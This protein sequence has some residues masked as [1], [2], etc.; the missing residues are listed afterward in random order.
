M[1][2]NKKIDELAPVPSPINATVYVAKD[3]VD[4][5]ATAGGANGLATLDASG[6]LP[7]SQVTPPTWGTITGTISAQADLSAA[8]AGKANVTHTHLIAD[9]TGLQTSLDSKLNLSGGNLT[10]QL[11][12]FQG[13][14]TT[15]QTYRR[16]GWNNNILRWSEVMEPNAGYALYSYDSLGGTPT[17]TLSIRT[18]VAGGA[19]VIQFKGQTMW[20]VGNDGSGSGLDADLLDGLDST[21]FSQV[22]H[23]HTI[24]NVTGLQ[25]EL[26]SKVVNGGSVA[27][28]L[29]ITQAAYDALGVKDANTLYVIVG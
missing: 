12:H 29:K 27:T 14:L 25:T 18:T 6:K 17:A 1:S 24:A 5:R 13:A 26:D 19:D 4:Y 28:I 23:T 16:I 22:G 3:G 9:I 11:G 10:G 15:Q 2:G 20:H 7:S 21:A 8:L